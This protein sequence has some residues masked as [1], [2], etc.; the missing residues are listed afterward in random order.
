MVSQ[1]IGH[2][3]GQTNS[4]ELDSSLALRYFMQ[5]A[6]IPGIQIMTWMSNIWQT[7]NLLRFTRLVWYSD[8]YCTP[9][10]IKREFEY[11]NHLNAGLVWYS[12]GRF[13]SDCQMVQ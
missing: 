6:W 13:V 7:D 11:S 4:R 10:Q 5:N 2:M 12:N 3:I 8:P 9:H 1:V